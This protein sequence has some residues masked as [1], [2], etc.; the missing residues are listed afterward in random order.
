MGPPPPPQDRPPMDLSAAPTARE[1]LAKLDA[2]TTTSEE[3]VEGYLRRAEALGR[4]NVFVHL[5]REAVLAQARQADARRR[6]GER[7]GRLDGVPVAIK[8]VLCVL[9]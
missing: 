9:G 3:L 7:L 1:L 2:G 4:L 8:D 6:A 5:D